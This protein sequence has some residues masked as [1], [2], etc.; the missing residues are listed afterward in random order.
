MRKHRCLIPQTPLCLSCEKKQHCCKE[1]TQS[2]P[3]KRPRCQSGHW[4]I[5]LLK[6]AEGLASYVKLLIRLTLILEP[7]YDQKWIPR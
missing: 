4:E 3:Q 2:A 6:I 7:D 5:R 1:H